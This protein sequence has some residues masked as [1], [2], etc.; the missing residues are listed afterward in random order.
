MLDKAINE[1]LD[2]PDKIYLS[3]DIDVLDPAFAPGTGTPEPGGLS[4]SQLLRAIRTISKSVEIVAVDI[5][6]VAPHYEGPASITAEAAHR[7]MLEAI[8]GI[9]VYRKNN[10]T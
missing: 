8:S 1:A 3:V 5:V 6:E 9:A 7:I 4:S 2:G 10:R